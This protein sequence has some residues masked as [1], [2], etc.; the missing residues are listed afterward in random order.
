MAALKI[1]FDTPDHPGSSASIAGMPIDFA[2]IERQT[3]GDKG[4]EMEVLQLFARQARQ[5]MAEIAGGE[6]EVCREAAHRLKGAALAVGAARVADAA[7]A[8]EG[9]PTDTSLRGAVGRAVLE[10]ELFILKLC[11]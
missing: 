6:A 3:M 7:A 8:L 4:L 9:Q 10:T 11:R 1:A 5:A 2:H